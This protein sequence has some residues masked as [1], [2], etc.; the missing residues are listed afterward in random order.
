LGQD[1]VFRMHMQPISEATS[2]VRAL[3]NW[4]FEASSTISP[5]NC[6]LTPS[7]FNNA[8]VGQ[9]ATSRRVILTEHALCPDLKFEFLRQETHQFDSLSETCS[10]MSILEICMLA[11][12]RRLDCRGMTKLTM[13]V[14]PLS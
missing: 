4:T 11:A 8:E 10:S 2:D 1:P 9:F 5:D 13:E 12:M 6:L 3:L 7:S 14:Q